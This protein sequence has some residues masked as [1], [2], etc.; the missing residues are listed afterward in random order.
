MKPG[1]ANRPQDKSPVG[2]IKAELDGIAKD[3]MGGFRSKEQTYRNRLIFSCTVEF[4]HDHVLPVVA[5]L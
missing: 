5:F 1:K 2:D 3:M 4:W